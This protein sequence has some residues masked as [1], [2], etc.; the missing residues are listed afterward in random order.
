MRPIQPARRAAALALAG[1]LLLAADAAGAQRQPPPAPMPARPLQFPAFRETSLPNGLRLLVVENHAHPV[2]SVYLLVGAGSAAVPAERA[3][4]AGEMAELLTKG[5]A[6][7]TGAQVS[8]AIEATGGS[9]GAG[10]TEDYTQ[11]YASVL[12]EHVP[13]AM[14]LLADVALHPS[15]PQ[16]EVASTVGRSQ[17]QLQQW[18]ADPSYVANRRF[19]ERLYGTHPY[20]RFRTSESLAALDRQAFVDFHRAH[21]HPGNALL[22]V[23]GDVDAARVEAMARERFGGWAPREAAAPRYAGLPSASPTRILL[24][25]RPGAVQSSVR[26]GTLAIR[27]GDADYPALLVMN[28]ILGGGTDSRLFNILREQRGWTYGAYTGVTR[29]RDTGRVMAEM[30]VRSEVTDSAVAEL[31]GQM[32]RM[33]AEPVSAEEMEAARGY[34]VGSF[35]IG[36]QT[37]EQVASQVAITRVLGLPVEDLLQRRERIAAVSA[38]DVRRVAARYLRPDSLTV[39]VV[40]DAARVMAGLERIAP[41][42]LMDLEGRPMDRA[43]LEVRASGERFDMA[44]L[45]AATLEYTFLGGGNPVGRSTSTLSQDGA[46]WKSALA[47]QFGPVQQTITARW[48]ADWTPVDYAETYAGAFDGRAEVKLENGRLTGSAAMPAQAGGNKTFDAAMVPGGAWSMMDEVMLSTADLAEGKTIVIPVFNTSTGAVAPVTFKVGATESV[49]VPAGT[50]QAFRVD[51]T[52]GSSPLTLWLRAEGPHIVVRQELV[53][54]PLVSE[55][56]AIR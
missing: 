31:L 20:G 25:H 56:T 49:T 21:F 4:L 29:P 3:G 46:G 22:V 55:L 28:K 13:L 1:A 8:G 6:T 18:M 37:A 33:A 2:A 39:V 16:D 23:A 41:V 14:E 40:G 54:Q 45:R 34:L 24:V 17:A 32:R 43:A 27:A 5:T 42:E 52:G 44:R 11:V 36:V 35:P 9:I 12:S 48:G 53:G 26:A 50:F 30:E 38:D 47:L 10:A 15:F 7:R 19:G 51:A